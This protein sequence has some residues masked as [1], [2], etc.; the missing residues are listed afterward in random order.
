MLAPLNAGLDVIID[1]KTTGAAFHG[2]IIGEE[3]NFVATLRAFFDR[4]GGSA[5]VRSS[6]AMVQHGM[7]YSCKSVGMTVKEFSGQSTLFSRYPKM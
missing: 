5:E 3:L 4:Q 6:R 7:R 1:D 2:D